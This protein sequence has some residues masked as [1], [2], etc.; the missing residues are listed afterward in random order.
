MIGRRVPPIVPGGCHDDCSGSL[1]EGDGRLQGVRGGHDPEEDLRDRR[2]GQ[3]GEHDAERTGGGLER[4]RERTPRCRESERLLLLAKVDDDGAPGSHA[5]V[6]DL[7]PIGG[8]PT[9][10]ERL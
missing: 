5:D 3:R 7:G 4:K 8:C 6:H 9:D 10:R 2:A 1:R